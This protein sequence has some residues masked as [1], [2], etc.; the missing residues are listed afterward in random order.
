MQQFVLVSW[1]KMN[2]FSV[3]AFPPVKNSCFTVEL[4][5]V[6][7]KK[8]GYIYTNVSASNGADRP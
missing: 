6:V 4:P 5:V 2:L 3:E 1:L 7:R 8:R